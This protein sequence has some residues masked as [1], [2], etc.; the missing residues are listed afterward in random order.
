VRRSVGLLARCLTY[1]NSPLDR[2]I[3]TSGLIVIVDEMASNERPSQG[4][5]QEEGGMSRNT[6]TTESN[7]ALK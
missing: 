5:Y 3:I 1:W 7:Q 2:Q 6:A 4:N